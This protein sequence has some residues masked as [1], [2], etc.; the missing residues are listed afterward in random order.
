MQEGYWQRLPDSDIA[1]P[2]LSQAPDPP[3]IPPV[4]SALDLPKTH[5]FDAMCV[6][7][8]QTVSSWRIPI[9]Q[10]KC[11]GRGNYQRTRLSTSGFPRGYLCAAS[12]SLDFRP[13]TWFAPR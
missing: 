6:G 7:R 9:L 13:E 4:P 5:A 11:T 3:I 10:I 12:L 1:P 2:D 8:F